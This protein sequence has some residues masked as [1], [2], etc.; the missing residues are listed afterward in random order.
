[1]NNQHVVF[2]TYLS[3]VH[4][5]HNIGLFVKTLLSIYIHTIRFIGIIGVCDEAAVIPEISF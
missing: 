1:M 4:F 5:H 3:I 2:M